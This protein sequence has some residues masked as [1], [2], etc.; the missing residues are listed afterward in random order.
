VRG[1]EVEVQLDEPP[2]RASVT[3]GAGAPPALGA[4]VAVRLSGVD[5]EAGAVRLELA[6]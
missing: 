4:P 3:A 6:G 2:V 1:A 5:V